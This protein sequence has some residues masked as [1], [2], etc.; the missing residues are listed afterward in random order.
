MPVML[1]IHRA[2]MP[3]S[4]NTHPMSNSQNLI[5]VNLTPAYLLSL[6]TGM[7][8]VALSLAG[9][10]IPARI[11][12]AVDLQ[13]SFTV[14]DFVNIFI[15]LPVLIVSMWLS[16]Q[17]NLAGLLFWPGA[18]L[19]I[20]YNYIAYLFG[21]PFSLISLGYLALILLS[22]YIIFVLI[23][24]IDRKYVKNRLTGRVPEKLTGWFL[25]AFG[26]LF[27]FRAIGMLVPAIMNDTGLPASEIGTLVAD[28]VLST[29][30]VVGGIL[31]LRH[32]PLGYAGGLGLLFSASMLFVGLVVYLLLQPVLS[33]TPLAWVD[34]I[35][36]LIMGLICGIPFALFLRGVLI[37]KVAS[38]P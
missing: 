18:L 4:K 7:L 31:I 26:V 17:D 1:I 6:V 35:V 34:V 20:L 11:Y 13:N 10:F 15:G 29:L 37:S 12:P 14:N 27:L 9:I 24:C 23:K 30:W 36:V 19:Y 5:R 3:Y 22:S 32:N 8:M 33:D 38:Y 28:L 2:P 21:L 25:V 16:R